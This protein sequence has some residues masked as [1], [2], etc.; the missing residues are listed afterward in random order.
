MSQMSK[1]KGVGKRESQLWHL[2][3]PWIALQGIVE[4]LHGTFDAFTSATGILI[5]FERVH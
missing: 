5:L 2:K 4:T 1:E 3:E